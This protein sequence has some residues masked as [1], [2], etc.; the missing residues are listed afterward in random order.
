MK[1]YLTKKIFGCTV[2]GEGMN[3]GRACYFWRAGGCNAWDGRP[4]TKA[5]SACPYCDTDFR[6]GELLTSYEIFARLKAIGY[7]EKVHGL[8]LTGG[9]PT[10]QLDDDF[11]AFFSTRAAWIDV[12]TNGTRDFRQG[13]WPNTFVSCSPKNV[14][15]QSLK[16]TK[17]DWWKILIPHQKMFL[18]IAMAT[19]KTVY[20]QPVM[21]QEGVAPDLEYADNL[22]ECLRLIYANPSLRLSLQVHKIAGVE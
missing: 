10:L 11:M 4:E 15:G 5:T 8:V 12:E 6:G 9:E 21:P 7:D 19:G 14:K 16:I 22:R 1:R 13:Y 18:N 17:P 20:L 2:Q 3:V